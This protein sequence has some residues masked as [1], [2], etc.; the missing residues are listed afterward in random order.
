MRVGVYLPIKYVEKE[1]TCTEESECRNKSPFIETGKIYEITA[2]LKDPVD[3]KEAFSKISDAI[4]QVRKKWPGISI[5]WIEISDDGKEIR[6]QI[7]DPRP[8]EVEAQSITVAVIVIAIAII[9]VM[10]AAYFFG[11]I[12]LLKMTVGVFYQPPP[13]ESAPIQDKLLYYTKQFALP[14]GIIGVSTYLVIKA[15]KR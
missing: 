7:F 9:S 8:P 3:P 11:V 2:R 5:N 13:P 6:M 14:I 1:V 10:A 12:D 4:I 15:I